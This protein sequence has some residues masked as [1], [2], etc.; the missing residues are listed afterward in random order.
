[1]GWFGEADW[2]VSGRAGPSAPSRSRTG[3]ACRRARRRWA[4]RSRAARRE[5]G[6]LGV[7]VRRAALTGAVRSDGPGAFDFIQGDNSSQSQ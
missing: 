5:C 1:M 4:T 2:V 3:R 7:V 6:A